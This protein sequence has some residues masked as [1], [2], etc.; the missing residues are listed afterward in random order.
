MAHTAVACRPEVT[1]CKNGRSASEGVT[2][3]CAWFIRRRCLCGEGISGSAPAW[4]LASCWP[5]VWLELHASWVAVRLPLAWGPLPRGEWFL[6]ACFMVFPL[7]TRQH[8][9]QGPWAEGWPIGITLWRCCWGHDLAGTERRH[10]VWRRPPWCTSRL[11][12]GP[13]GRDHQL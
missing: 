11:Q 1:S 4:A 9:T 13:S 6:R 10:M 2:Y 12:M 7:G 3:G 5:V 8:A